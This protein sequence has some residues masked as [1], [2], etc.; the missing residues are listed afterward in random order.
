MAT[1]PELMS[2][3]EKAYDEYADARMGAATAKANYERAR[4]GAFARSQEKSQSGRQ[5]EA[6][7]V[8]IEEKVALLRAE[9]MAEITKTHVQ[10]LLGE[11]VAA[12][13][14]QKFAGKIDGG[15]GW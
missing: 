7:V 3:L 1:V 2:A 5:S 12:Q 8:A 9:A 14:V 4:L 13:S 11:L 15:D 10:V 6:E